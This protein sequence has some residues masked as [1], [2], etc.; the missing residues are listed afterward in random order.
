MKTLAVKSEYNKQ[1]ES[2]A[3]DPSDEDERRSSKTHDSGEDFDAGETKRSLEDRSVDGVGGETANGRDQED[4]AGTEANLRQGG[5]LHDEGG[6]E[7]DV[8]AGAETKQDGEGDE[9]GV[10]SIWN[11]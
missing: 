9:G 10:A 5:D 7:R 3:M 4:K 2:S 6:D 8:S 11:P 1:L